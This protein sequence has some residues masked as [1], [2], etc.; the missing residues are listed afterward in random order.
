MEQLLKYRFIIQILAGALLGMLISITIYLFDGFSEDMISNRWA[1]FWQVV[2]SGLNGAVCMGS[3]IIYEF[4]KWGLRKVT[5]LHY[6][7]CLLSFLTA[8]LLLQWFP[9]STFC[10]VL[11]VYTFV[12]FIVW[13][14]EYVFWK[15][16]IR[17]IN[18]DL[19]KF[20]KKDREGAHP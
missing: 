16:E 11:P 17:K 15:R 18:Q 4:E 10:I 8:C 7:I 2:G 3:S 5:I 19:E 14:M 6:L 9:I 20:L 1:F 12:Y 13:V